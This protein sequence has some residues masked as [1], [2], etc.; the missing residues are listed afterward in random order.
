MKFFLFL[1]QCLGSTKITKSKQQPLKMILSN[2]VGHRYQMD[3][4]EMPIYDRFCYIL[5]VVDHLSLYG[6]VAPIQHCSSNEVGTALLRILCQAIVPVILQSDNGGEVRIFI[7]LCLH[8]LYLIQTLFFS[9]KFLY[10]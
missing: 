7:E 3:L 8:L 5:C 1:S 2:K 6:F 10:L 9:C 4:I